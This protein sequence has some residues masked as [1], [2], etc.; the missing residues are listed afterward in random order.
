MNTANIDEKYSFNDPVWSFIGEFPLEILL[1]IVDRGDRTT[2][3]LNFQSFD[4]LGIGFELIRIIER[5]L[6]W[7]AREML[8]QLNQRGF[9]AP[10]RIRLFCLKK[11]IAEANYK[12]SSNKAAKRNGLKTNQAFRQPDIEAGGGWGYFLVKRSGNLQSGVDASS[13]NYIDLYLYKEGG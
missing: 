10:A 4:D 1:T 6:T 5:K 7:F 9:D 3:G 8:V 12:H 2:A 13:N 11:T